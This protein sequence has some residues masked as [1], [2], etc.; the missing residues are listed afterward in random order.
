M[1]AYARRIE[2]NTNWNEDTV[3]RLKDTL[4]YYLFFY[5]LFLVLLHSAFLLL[6]CP[7]L[8]FI[9]W[10]FKALV[11]SLL[12]AYDPWVVW[13][14]ACFVC[15]HFGFV[16][17]WKRAKSHRCGGGLLS[18][19]LQ[20]GFSDLSE[21]LG[22]STTSQGEFWAESESV[23]D[24]LLVFSPDYFD[25]WCQQLLSWGFGWGKWL[26]CWFVCWFGCL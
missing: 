13:A 23:A 26:V 22:W 20:N 21:A 8:S 9:S 15:I 12:W 7:D 17:P 19:V 6:F 5:P 2:R 18:R 11:I 16:C 4:W 14:I 25:T 10:L 3:E 24:L 1:C